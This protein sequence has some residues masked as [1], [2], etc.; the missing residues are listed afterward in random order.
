MRFIKLVEF[1]L[2]CENLERHLTPNLHV[3]MK[4]SHSLVDSYRPMLT[5]DNLNHKVQMKRTQKDIKKKDKELA[6]VE[7]D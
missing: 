3:F 2:N 6:F 7:G 5:K 4:T 1:V